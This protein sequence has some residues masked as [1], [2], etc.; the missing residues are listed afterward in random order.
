MNYRGINY[1]MKDGTEYIIRSIKPEEAAELL[2]L[3]KQTSGESLGM[4]RY[5]DDTFPSV[6]MEEKYLEHVMGSDNSA[7]I[8]AYVDGKLIG[9]AGVNCPGVGKRKVLHRCEIGLSIEKK[10]W[11]QQIGTRM[12]EALIELAQR[13][14]YE[15]ME[16]EVFTDNDRAIHLYKKMGFEIYGTR[17]NAMKLD[18]GTYQDEHLMVKYLKARFDAE[19]KATSDLEEWIE[20]QGIQLRY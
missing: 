8:G 19:E 18:D 1:K 12:I 17:P 4:L 6:G 14:G 2:R 10:Y 13:V 5:P 3:M 16:L 7:Q 9:A 11:D 20:E 15:Q